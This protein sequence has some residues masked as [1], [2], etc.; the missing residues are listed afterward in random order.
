MGFD[1]GRPC[2]GA[3]GG[4]GDEPGGWLAGGRQRRASPCFRTA[5]GWGPRVCV[6]KVC[7]QQT[8]VL[9]GM[10]GVCMCAAQRVYRGWDGRGW[11]GSPCSCAV[12]VG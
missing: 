6:A 8:N 5:Q 3:V 4:A 12:G 1:L 9:A 7:V 2:G 11:R 10:Q